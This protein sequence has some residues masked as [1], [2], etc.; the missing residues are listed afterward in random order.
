MINNKELWKSYRIYP[1][2]EGI[3]IGLFVFFAIFMTTFF[4]YQYS[5]DAQ[6]GE[7]K[8]GLLRTAKV[9]GA[10][11][12]ADVHQNLIVGQETSNNYL[13][14]I[15]P[16]EVALKADESIK[17][18]Y[19]AILKDNKVF[20][21]LDATAAGDLDGDGVEDKAGIMEEYPEAGT[22]IV[23][24]LTNHEIVISDTPYTDRWGSFLSAYVPLLN[25]RGESVAV[26]GI[27][28]EASE[29]FTRLEPIKRATTRTM[30]IGFFISFLVGSIVWFMRNFG[31][32]I[33]IKRKE[34]AE[35]VS[36]NLIKIRSSSE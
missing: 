22:E 15:K 29:Y 18:L 33:N 21:I 6:K 28:I 36:E 7:I 27:D 4:I 3:L 11:I 30:V 2:T 5:L 25:K 26:L 32:K 16:L 10:F 1:L 12:N 14:Q 20:F 9:V 13:Q 34:L 23:R 17:Y 24:A 8:E 31:L 35:Q 19:T